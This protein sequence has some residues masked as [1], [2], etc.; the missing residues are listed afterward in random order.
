MMAGLSATGDRLMKVSVWF[1]PIGSSPISSEPARATIC[2]RLG[3]DL[4]QRALEA[5]IDVQRGI[6][7]DRRQLFQ[8]HDE[9]AL[10]HGRHE[11]LAQ[12]HVDDDRRDERAGRRRRATMPAR[13]ARAAAA[14]R[15]ASGQR[16][17]QPRVGVRA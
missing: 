13:P 12:P 16:A 2:N 11:G 9:A 4:L 17:R 14:A 5:G 8:L 15:T 3:H 6:E 1:R 10:V 7:A